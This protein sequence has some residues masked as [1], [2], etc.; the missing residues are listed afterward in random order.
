MKGIQSRKPSME[1]QANKGIGLFDQ[2]T[3]KFRAPQQGERATHQWTGSGYQ[4]IPRTAE[5][6]DAKAKA[7]EARQREKANTDRET[8]I[9]GHVGKILTDEFVIQYPSY[10]A[11]AKEARKRAETIVGAGD[12]T[13]EDGPVWDAKTSTF[14]DKP[15]QPPGKNVGELP[16][17]GVDTSKR[18]TDNATP[19]PGMGTTT[20]TSQ[21]AVRMT[22]GGAVK[23]TVTTG[24]GSVGVQTN[25][26]YVEL[27]PNQVAGVDT[28][29]EAAATLDTIKSGAQ[30]SWNAMKQAGEWAV[31]MAEQ[32]REKKAA[33]QATKRQQT[34]DRMKAEM[35]DRQENVSYRAGKE[36]AARRDRLGLA[37][38]LGPLPLEER[39]RL[40]RERAQRR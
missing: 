37:P 38:S 12:A 19:Y 40:R 34:K 15:P 39:E 27:N 36:A 4:E 24:G 14:T 29:A 16:V 3:G 31:K 21:G 9:Q 30:T 7:Q 5:A 1:D 23:G 8:A 28:K 2:G 18:A 20:T 13:E 32:Q 6:A 26:G 33:A 25:G 11:A 35:K 22:S 10:A 17:P